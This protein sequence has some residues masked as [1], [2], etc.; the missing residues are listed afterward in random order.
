MVKG[1]PI[2][3]GLRPAPLLGGQDRLPRKS[4]RHESATRSSC[5]M[6]GTEMM[7]VAP[8]LALTPFLVEGSEN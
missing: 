4:A 6:E 5:G 3:L 8:G 1:E 7:V 2:H